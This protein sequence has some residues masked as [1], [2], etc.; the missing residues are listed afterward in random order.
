MAAS[1][2]A[3]QRVGLA[4]VAKKNS[5]TRRLYTAKTY[6]LWFLIPSATLFVIFFL[7]PTVASFYFAF[8]RWDLPSATWTGW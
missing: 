2:V 1:E 4:S 6:P 7:V 8:T 5:S 3:P